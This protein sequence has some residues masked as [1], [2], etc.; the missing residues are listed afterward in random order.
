MS[1]WFWRSIQYLLIAA[2]TGSLIYMSRPRYARE[3]ELVA[4]AFIALLVALV[5]VRIV[6]VLALWLDVKEA[7]LRKRA[8]K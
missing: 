7:E 8:G 5:A 4:I 1:L 3:D 6:R 2:G